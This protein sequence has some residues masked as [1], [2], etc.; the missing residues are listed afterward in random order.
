MVKLFQLNTLIPKECQ[1]TYFDLNKEIRLF[2]DAAPSGFEQILAQGDINYPEKMT[3]TSRYVLYR[4]HNNVTVKLR[5]KYVQ[6]HGQQ[7]I[8]TLTYIA[9]YL[10]CILNTDHL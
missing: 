9:V 5:K 2:V 3:Y 8:F 7:N 4:Q 10:F 1:L 6:L